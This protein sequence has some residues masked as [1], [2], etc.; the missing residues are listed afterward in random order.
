MEE[1]SIRF[2]PKLQ[3]RQL[4]VNIYLTVMFYYYWLTSCHIWWSIKAP[5]DCIISDLWYLLPFGVS[6]KTIMIKRKIIESSHLRTNLP[7]FHLCSQTETH[8]VSLLYFQRKTCIWSH[9]TRTWRKHM[10]TLIS[11]STW[12]HPNYT[13]YICVELWMCP[14]NKEST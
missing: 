11:E 6:V 13:F 12:Q 3:L 2:L 7:L 5:V 9:Q 10:T 8:G 4:R 14:G 1:W